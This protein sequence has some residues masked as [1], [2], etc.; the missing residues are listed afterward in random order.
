MLTVTQ[1][2]DAIDENVLYPAG[3]SVWVVEC[4]VVAHLHRIEHHHIGIKACRKLAALTQFQIRRRQTT[5]LM[6]RFLKR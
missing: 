4:G 6:Y 5:E 3:I 2:G 1:Y